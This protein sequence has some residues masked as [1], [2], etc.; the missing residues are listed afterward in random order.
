MWLV[1]S[2]SCCAMSNDHAMSS[3]TSI[4]QNNGSSGA[5]KIDNVLVSVFDHPSMILQHMQEA[6]YGQ[7]NIHILVHWL[8]SGKWK[9]VILCLFD[10]PSIILLHVQ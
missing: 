8:N 7:S 10:H 6:F 5:W 4:Y 2:S 3:L 9:N 1:S